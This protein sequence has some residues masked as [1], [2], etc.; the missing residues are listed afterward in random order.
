MRAHLLTFGSIEIDGRRYD[1]DVVIERGAVRK[2]GKKPSKPYRDAYGHTPLSADE[3]TPWGGR[4]LIIGTGVSG[5]LPVM[6]EVERE[7]RR[8]RPAQEGDDTGTTRRTGRSAAI[9]SNASTGSCR[10]TVMCG[11]PP[12]TFWT[13]RLITAARSPTGT[14]TRRTRRAPRRRRVAAPPAARTFATQLHSPSMET[15]YHC[16]PTS[17]MPRGNRVTRPVRRPVTSRETQRLG[18]RPSPSALLQNRAYRRAV[19]LPRPPTYIARSLS[20]WR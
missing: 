2:R 19:A 8:V 10:S 17:A 7:A 16:P 5:S 11:R 20:S 15:R 14:G 12:G 1:H 18:R 9:D 3:E 13:Y 4:L 6:P